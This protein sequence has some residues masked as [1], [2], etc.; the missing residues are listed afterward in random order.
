MVLMGLVGRMSTLSFDSFFFSPSLLR[1]LEGNGVDI[2]DFAS[3][4]KVVYIQFAT[5]WQH[6]KMD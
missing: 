2:C 3:V 5:R 1:E 4:Y 6:C